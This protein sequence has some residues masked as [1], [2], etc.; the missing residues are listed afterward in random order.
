[1]TD[2]I[3]EGVAKYDPHRQIW[4]CRWCLKELIELVHKN[5]TVTFLCPSKGRYMT[6]ID[7]KLNRKEKT[8]A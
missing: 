1:M 4:V 2:Y 3:K 7:C 5:D 6:C 8:D